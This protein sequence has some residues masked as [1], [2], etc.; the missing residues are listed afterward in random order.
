M[1]GKELVKALHD[2]TR[3]YGTC[4]VSPSPMWPPMIAGLGMDFVF[5]DTEH[6][7][8]GRETLSWMCRAYTALGLAP[9]VRIPKPDPFLA[10][11]ALDGG[12]VGVIAPYLESVDQVREL[13]G[14]VKLRPLKGQRL[15]NYLAGTETLEPE[16]QQY[17]DTRNADRV[18]VVNVESV[19]ALKA[20]DDILAVPGIDALLVGPHDLS[21]NLGIPEQYTHPRF[22][23]AIGTI[24]AKARK[25]GVGVGIH[26][27]GGIDLE[28]AWAREGANFIIHSSDVSLVNDALKRDL[29]EFKRQLGDVAPQEVSGAT[30][31]I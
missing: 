11:M 10:C 27:S 21:I 20:L 6:V 13:R 12:A 23:E 19:P 18:M 25:A 8:I 9:V 22:L 24:I 30:D 2:G 4:V 5:I 31:A 26:Y 14:A 17:L 16:V 1:N 3:V 28:I 29:A 15:Q 7:A